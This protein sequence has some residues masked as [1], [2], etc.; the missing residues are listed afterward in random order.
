MS[1]RKNKGTSNDVVLRLPL[2][3][4]G[5]ILDALS[6]QAET[7]QYTGE[8]LEGREIREDVSCKEC[9][10]PKEAWSIMLIETGV[11]SENSERWDGGFWLFG[12]ADHESPH[13]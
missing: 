8:F 5:Q 7:W 1:E 2:F 4:V 6:D 11:A 3:A 13:A 10:S 12:N 9:S